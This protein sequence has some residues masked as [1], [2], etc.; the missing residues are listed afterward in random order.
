MCR[1]LVTYKYRREEAVAGENDDGVVSA[2][3][4]PRNRLNVLT[5]S[6]NDSQ[7]WPLP[8]RR[9]PVYIAWFTAFPT[10]LQ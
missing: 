7:R 5:L 9:R 6:P 1:V 2:A 8:R 10:W 4:L 3:L